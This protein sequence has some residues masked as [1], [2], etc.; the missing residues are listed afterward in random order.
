MEV[1]NL[2]ENNRGRQKQNTPEENRGKWSRHGD[3]DIP[4]SREFGTFS[5]WRGRSRVDRSAMEEDACD[6]E[7]RRGRRN[8]S[9]R[10]RERR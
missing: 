10:E 1:Q 4:E 5:S 6:D 3:E 7:R 2:K 9:E 8:N